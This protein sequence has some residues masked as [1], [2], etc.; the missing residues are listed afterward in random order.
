MTRDDQ[1]RDGRMAVEH[2]VIR[3]AVPGDLPAVERIVEAAYRPWAELIGVRPKPMDDDYAARIAAGRVHLLE[4]PEKGIAGLIVLIPEDGV[5]LVDNVAV[6]P[7]RHGRGLGRALLTFAE[8]QARTAGLGALRL[9]TNA[10]MEPNIALYERLGYRIT[11]RRRSG[12]REVVFM[13]KLLDD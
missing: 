7:D 10:L 5:L 11:E 3:L 13:T 8:V 1:T 12:P 9:Y 6:V 4:E 2:R